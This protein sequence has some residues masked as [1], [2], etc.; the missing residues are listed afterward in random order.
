MVLVQTLFTTPSLFDGGDFSASGGWDGYSTPFPIPLADSVFQGY[1][2]N[3]GGYDNQPSNSPFINQPYSGYNTNWGSVNED[4]VIG[5]FVNNIY[6]GYNTNWGQIVESTDVPPSLVDVDL[7]SVVDHPKDQTVYYKLKG[8][9]STTLSYEVWVI[10]HNITARLPLDGSLFDPDPGRSPP[11]IE[12]D[13]FKTNPSGN[14][15]ID[16]VITARWL[17]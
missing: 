17:E 8:W 13:I 5:A 1:F 14:P 4:T 2:E 10:S 12:R 16:I 3:W 11:E 9:N 7:D 15:L 6:A